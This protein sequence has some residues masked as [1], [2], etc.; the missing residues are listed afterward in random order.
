MTSLAI[1]VP[2]MI[3]TG[4]CGLGTLLAAESSV[5]GIQDYSTPGMI[6]GALF[7]FIG[8]AAAVLY[9]VVLAPLFGVFIE[10]LKNSEQDKRTTLK[11]LKDLM[12]K[13]NSH[14]ESEKGA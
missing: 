3:I 9:K 8:T 1:K 13:V 4:T 11:D 12:E 6:I 2:I 10:N 14:L 5:V 7:I